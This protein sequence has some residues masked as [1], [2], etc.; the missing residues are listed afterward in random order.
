MRETFPIP[1]PIH[2]QKQACRMP[3]PVARPEPQ[4]QPPVPWWEVTIPLTLGA[5]AAVCTAATIIG[6]IIHAL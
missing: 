2:Q 4:Q 5:T 6:Q 3:L 1:A